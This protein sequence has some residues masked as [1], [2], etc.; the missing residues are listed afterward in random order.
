MYYA[1]L[2]ADIS[3]R[4]PP[5][6]PSILPLLEDRLELDVAVSEGAE[7]YSWHGEHRFSSHQRHT[8]H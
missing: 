2:K 7:I 5:A 1:T 6:I 8:G 4:Q 3:C